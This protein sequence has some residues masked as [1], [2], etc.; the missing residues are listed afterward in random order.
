MTN[1]TSLHKIEEIKQTNVYYCSNLF[2]DFEEE[3]DMQIFDVLS[4]DYLPWTQGKVKYD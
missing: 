3:I 1:N 2:S 4:S